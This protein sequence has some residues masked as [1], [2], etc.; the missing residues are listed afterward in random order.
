MGVNGGVHGP[1]YTDY[2]KGGMG[3]ERAMTLKSSIREDASKLCS[4]RGYCPRPSPQLIGGHL[5]MCRLYKEIY[6]DARDAYFLQGFLTI[7]S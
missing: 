2:F 7:V 3:R 6:R 5:A 1:L 4:N